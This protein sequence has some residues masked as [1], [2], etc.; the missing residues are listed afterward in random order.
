MF[1][2][3]LTIF[4]GASRLLR[5]AKFLEP[6]GSTERRTSK[7]FRSYAGA[8]RKSTEKPF[9]TFAAARD[10]G[11]A[12]RPRQQPDHD[13]QIYLQGLN[14]EQREAVLAPVGPM[15]VLAGP[16]SGKTRVLTCRVAHLL[17]TEEVDPSQILCITFTNKAAGELKERLSTLLG[18]QG[19]HRKL[20]VGTFHSLAARMLRQMLR[21]PM[22]PEGP[23]RAPGMSG[24]SEL[25]PSDLIKQ[26][27]YFGLES[28]F[29]I[30]DGDDSTKLI[31]RI[32]SEDKDSQHLDTQE[33]RQTVS[34]VQKV[35][36]L[37]KGGAQF[38]DLLKSHEKAWWYEE[39]FRKYELGLRQANAVDFDDLLSI[40]VAVMQRW[41]AELERWRHR[42]QHVLVD[43]FQDTSKVQFEMVRLLAEKHG[44]L[45]VVGDPNQAIYSWRGAEVANIRDRFQQSFNHASEYRLQRNYRSMRSIQVV[46]AS[47]I[48][49][50]RSE[51]ANIVAAGCGGEQRAYDGDAS[52][53]GGRWRG[54]AIGALQFGGEAEQVAAEVRRLWDAGEELSSMAVLFRTNRQVYALEKALLQEGVPA[55]WFGGMSLADRVEVKDVLAYLRLLVNGNDDAALLRVI[56]VPP[57]GIGPKALESLQQWAVRTAEAAAEEAAAVKKETEAAEV[58]VVSAGTAALAEDPL[59]APPPSP[60]AATHSKPPPAPPPAS[61]STSSPVSALPPLAERMADWF[62]DETAACHASASAVYLLINSDGSRSYVGSTLDLP[63]RL[64]QHNREAPGGAKATAPGRPW[65]IAMVLRGCE[66]K[67]DALSVE[68]TWKGVKRVPRKLPSSVSDPLQ[69]PQGSVWADVPVLLRRNMQLAVARQVALDSGDQRKVDLWQRVTPDWTPNNVVLS[70]VSAS[71]AASSPAPPAPASL[72]VEPGSRDQSAAQSAAGRSPAAAFPTDAEPLQRSLA[73]TLARLPGGVLPPKKD[74]GLT[75]PAYKSLGLAPSPSYFSPRAVGEGIVKVPKRAVLGEI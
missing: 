56:N 66:S 54:V 11:D 19:Q 65:R 36:S 70:S 49:M 2:R 62:V 50:R 22:P 14:P 20:A 13:T 48:A 5:R 3:H 34:R 28:N 68:A 38:R 43:E 44:S 9:R 12:S 58:E 23:Q 51:M 75:A 69:L 15:R 21:K 8:F 1:S 4:F 71:A 32:V 24:I 18:E 33:L 29:T 74:L 10:A 41:P 30:Y 26:R 42:F 53:A 61:L 40:T 17:S 45:F 6:S 63:R 39:I 7:S 67:E 16:G 27:G 47:A 52:P 57:R 60:E 31:K 59:P 35:I 72:G 25:I 64:R 55:V 73:A 37:V 46:A